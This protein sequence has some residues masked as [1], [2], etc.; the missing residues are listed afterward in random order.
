MLGAV[1]THVYPVLTTVCLA[2]FGSRK[3]SLVEPKGE[4]AVF[5]LSNTALYIAKSVSDF[6]HDRKRQLW[7]KSAFLGVKSMKF[8]RTFLVYSPKGGDDEKIKKGE[9][10]ATAILKDKAK[11]NRLVVDEA[12]NDDN[13]VVTLSQVRVDRDPTIG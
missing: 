11:P 10:L 1:T 5:D 4:A 6:I 13:S 9:E 2:L 12:T 8:M 3:K 7:R